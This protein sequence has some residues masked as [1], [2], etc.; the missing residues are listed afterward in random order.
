MRLLIS[1]LLIVALAGCTHVRSSQ[2]VSVSGQGTWLVLP[3][4]NRTATPQAGL[5]A[6]AIVESVL[7][8]HGVERVEAYPDTENDGVL[9]EA[10]SPASRQKMTQWVSTQDAT[11][12]VSGVVHE[13]RYKTGV[14]GE[15]AVGVMLEIRELPS[16]EIVY[17]GTGSR[18]GWARDSLSET[19]QKV[20]DKLLKPVID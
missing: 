8:R 9:F 18:A 14:D 6:A 12:V 15:P 16:G 13:W 7:Y 5:R 2:D 10:S 19:G 20:I 3:L 11:Y 1:V 4:V 17:S